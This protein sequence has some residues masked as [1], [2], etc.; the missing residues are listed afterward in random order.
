M[1]I[2]VLILMSATLAL[3]GCQSRWNPTNWW[4]DDPVPV[5]EVN[6]LIPDTTDDGR[7]FF[8]AKEVAEFVGSPIQT[9]TSVEVHK[10]PEGNL[11]M[12][13]GVASVHGVS[14]VRLIPTNDGIPENGI[15]TL[16]LRGIYPED[17]IVGGA[18]VT[19]EVTTAV[20]LTEQHLNGART[21]RVSA[22]NNSIDRR[23]R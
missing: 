21:I 13:V 12:V 16:E 11:V 19:R 23:H 18:D 3:S 17:P 10:V 22:A 1:R 15:L 9:V 14:N 4:G 8:Q 5:G 2:S 6:P 20:V 7:S